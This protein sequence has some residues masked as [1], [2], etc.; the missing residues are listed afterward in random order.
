MHVLAEADHAHEPLGVAQ[1]AVRDVAGRARHV[2]PLHDQM[3]GQLPP[4]CCDLLL[5]PELPGAQRLR[6]R[7]RGRGRPREEG[8]VE[9]ILPS[10]CTGQH[11]LSAHAFVV[12]LHPVVHKAEGPPCGGSVELL[13]ATHAVR[14]GH[15][16]SPVV[17][18]NV[19]GR[20]RGVGSIPR[21]GASRPCLGD[22]AVQRPQ[23]RDPPRHVPQP[24][25][26]P[27]H[28]EGRAVRPRQDALRHVE[29]CAG[30]V[31]L[32]HRHDIAPRDA[33][34]GL[35]RERVLAVVN[36]EL[37]VERRSG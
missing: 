18:R 22:R 29:L 23:D 4:A 8:L 36:F 31:I 25:R 35:H 7:R 6:G 30:V 19:H 34:L 32:H 13:V 28:A 5:H 12:Q 15:G 3:V 24:V 37:Q 11:V 1:G 21:D 33:L 16:V 20:R 2:V 17:Q 14:L 27:L 10:C 26:A 9:A